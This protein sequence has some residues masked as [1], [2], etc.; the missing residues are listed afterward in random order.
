MPDSNGYRYLEPRSGCFRLLY[1]KGTKLRADQLYGQTVG[2]DALTP[3]EVAQ[4]FNLPLEAVL[5]VID[6]CQKHEELIIQERQEESAR[7]AEYDK[8]QRPLQPPGYV[9]QS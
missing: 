9:P 6:Y 2:E 7:L 5:E 1:I 8:R 3:E 4:D